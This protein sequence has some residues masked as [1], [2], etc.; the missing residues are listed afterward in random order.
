VEK[1]KNSARAAKGQRSYAVKSLKK[2][3]RKMLMLDHLTIIAPSLALGVAHVF[4]QLGIEMSSGG[5]HPEMGT[6]N[7]LLRLGDN[8]FIEVIAIDPEASPLSRV[9]WFGLDAADAIEKTWTSGNRLNGWVARTHDLAALLKQH[10]KLLGRSTLVS[11]GSL[12]WHISV[13]DDGSLPSGGV[14]PAVIDWGPS[15]CP[16]SRMPDLGCRLENFTI[17]HPDPAYVRQLYSDLAIIDPPI[18]AEAETFRYVAT[19]A[20]SVGP[21]ELR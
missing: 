1:P 7:R 12:S 10:G 19:I 21:R 14:S 17:E 20:T 16:A 2:G 3:K 11:R 6:H 18:I 9:R 15:G 8:V 13:T 5:K 4:Q